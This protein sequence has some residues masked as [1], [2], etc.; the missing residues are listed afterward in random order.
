V[1]F[2]LAEMGDKKQLATVAPAA[3]L[4]SVVLVTVGTTLGRLTGDDLASS[5]VSGSLQRSS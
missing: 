3:Q 5:S 2:F 4:K 1:L